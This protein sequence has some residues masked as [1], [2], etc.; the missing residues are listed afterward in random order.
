MN[1]IGSRK[2]SKFNPANIV[3]PEKEASALVSAIFERLDAALI[4]YCVERNYQGYPNVLTGDVDLIIGRSDIIIVAQHICDVAKANGWHCYQHYIWE[5][6]GYLGLCFN[7]LPNRFTLTIELFSGARWHGVTF[8]DGVTVI[9]DR[10]RHGI[11]WKPSPGHQI[12]ITV[13]HHLL[14]NGM[15]PQKYRDE[16]SSLMRFGEEAVETNLTPFFGKRHAKKVTKELIRENWQYF[17]YKTARRLKTLLLSRALIS[18]PLTTLNDV[19]KGLISHFR[20]PE[21]IVIIIDI[22]SDSIKNALIESM[23]G[24]MIKWH[25]FKPPRREVIRASV[26]VFKAKR[27]VAKILSSGGAVLID[28]ERASEFTGRCSLPEYKIVQSDKLVLFCQSVEIFS[29]SES[30]NTE[31]SNADRAAL[32][33]LNTILFHRAA[34]NKGLSFD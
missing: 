22:V 18:R 5:K 11:T 34:L 13:M 4:G 9:N 6:T 15:V 31:G 28:H 12:I 33:L 32:E 8:L 14:Y 1:M 27:L 21:G 7:G 10:L 17:D 30:L 2:I 20:G 26:S 19:R 24:I 3:L 23:L 25:V 16:I 29:C